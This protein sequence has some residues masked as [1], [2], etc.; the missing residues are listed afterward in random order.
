MVVNVRQHIIL[1]ALKG[2]LCKQQ[3]VQRLPELLLQV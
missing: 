2:F 1:A 3:D